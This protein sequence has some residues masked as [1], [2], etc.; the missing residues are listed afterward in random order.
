[1]EYPGHDV[2]TMFRLPPRALPTLHAILTANGWEDVRSINPVHHGKNIR[3]TE[4]N[5]KRIFS[6]ALLGVSSITRTSPQTMELVRR[7]KEANPEGIA[8]AGGCD[9][10]FR[11]EDWIRG[12]ADIVVRGEADRTFPDL[13]ERLTQDSSQLS[14]IQGITYTSLNEIR[15]NE[16]RKLL[17]SGELSLLPHPYY[18]EDIRR[19]AQIAVIE[20]SRGC[21]NACDFCSV[22]EFYGKKYRTKSSR[23]I[24]DELERIKEM[25]TNLFF[26]D[27]NFGG[28]PKRTIELLYEMSSRGLN[29]KWGSAQ[30]TVK[31]AENQELIQSFKKAGIQTLYV[32][33]ES[34]NDDTLNSLGKPYSAE[35]NKEN[36][37]ILRDEGFWIHGMMVVGGDGDT[38][39]TL[40][41]TT[42]WMKENLDSLQL[43]PLTPLP[44]T[45]FYQRM[46]EQ[47]RILTGDFSLYD[48]Q[49]VVFRPK[50]FT[51]Y[52]LQK[53][54]NTMYQEFYSPEE[55]AKRFL[56]APKKI[57]S[58]VIFTY[59]NLFGGLKSA[60]YS[61]QAVNHLEF[62]RSVS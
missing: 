20:T 21:P 24:I 10:T 42:A 17:T 37:Q 2:Y 19:G 52:E 51:P 62:L 18:D 14:D 28:N 4:Q 43:F 46:H 9:P 60:L 59:L 61:P 5:E 6:S 16:G 26:I 13:M 1:M 15:R 45:K 27:D 56:R 32:G 36:I 48:L 57:L 7:Y 50:N 38:K 23:Y 40:R 22:T 30:V 47:G 31:A 39:E 35:Q 55:I 41:E 54:I 29:K 53:T 44:G 3:L 34:I 25:G 12:G 11:E 49:M 8:V 33:I 58:L